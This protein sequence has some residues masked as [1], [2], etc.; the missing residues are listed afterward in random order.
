MTNNFSIVVRCYQINFTVVVKCYLINFISSE[1]SSEY[2]AV[3]GNIQD[4]LFMLQW[5]CGASAIIVI[6]TFVCFVVCSIYQ[7]GRVGR[8][9]PSCDSKHRDAWLF[10]TIFTAV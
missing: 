9:P 3:L 8:T 7:L 10:V 4:Y 2:P 5:L 1:V 6:L